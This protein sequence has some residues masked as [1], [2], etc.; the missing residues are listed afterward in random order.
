MTVFF[1]NEKNPRV[2]NREERGWRRRPTPSPGSGPAG[3]EQPP[4]ERR[5]ERP[6]RSRSFPLSRGGAGRR[7]RRGPAPAGGLWPPPKGGIGTG[8]RA[9]GN[10]TGAGRLAALG[11]VHSSFPISGH[12][13][14]GIRHPSSGSGGESPARIASAS[15]HSG[16]TFPAAP[17]Q[18]LI[19][20]RALS[21]PSRPRLVLP[22]ATGVPRGG[23][24]LLGCSP[25][26]RTLPHSLNPGT[27]RDRP[28]ARGRHRFRDFHPWAAESQGGRF[29]PACAAWPRPFVPGA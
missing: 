3:R 4:G 28:S 5:P 27:G 12:R 19:P 7:G 26:S 11:V 29:S 8:I 14:G 24:R 17:L 18:P 9:G 25:G 13:P 20:L 23:E 21:D 1:M 16:S 6:L 10:G 15:S 2:S 22:R